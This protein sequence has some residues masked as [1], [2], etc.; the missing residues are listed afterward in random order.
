[1][2]A[3]RSEAEG[4]ER[5]IPPGWWDAPKERATRGK[6]R[7]GGVAAPRSGAEG[8]ELRIP[9]GSWDAPKE[10]ATRGK[11]R[12][13]RPRADGLGILVVGRGGARLR[14]DHLQ[15]AGVLIGEPQLRKA[16]VDELLAQAVLPPG[17]EGV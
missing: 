13:G 16:V 5:R 15:H 17:R 8:D 6:L 3:P 11:L 2:A 7:Q 4:D 1:E 10:R 12:Q 14:R 9:P